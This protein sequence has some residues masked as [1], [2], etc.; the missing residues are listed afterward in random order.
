MGSGRFSADDWDVYATTS[1]YATKTVD[2]I[3]TARKLDDA[4]NPHGIKVRESHDSAD[5]PNSTAIIVALDVTGSMGM[6]LDTMAKEG[7][8]TLMAEIYD[9]K[10]VTDPHVMCMG[11]GDVEAGDKAPLQVTQFEADLRIAKQ[12]EKLYLERGGGGNSYESYA[13]AWYFAAKHTSIDCF[14]KRGKKG[15][16]FT[17]GDEKPT[18]Y[19]RREDIERVMGPSGLESDLLDIDSLLTMVSREWEVYHLIVEEGSYARGNHQVLEEWRK[20]LGQHAIPLSDHKKLAEVI[21][22]I[23]S[24]SAGMDAHTVV[25]SWD[26]ST[27]LVVSR[28]VSDIAVRTSSGG[29]INL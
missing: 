26:S 1:S 4:L 12:L 15:Y 11:I 18:P 2:A 29:V 19:L 22:S 13:L 7:L 23:L 10:P 28:A 6:L 25:R 17:L 27:S 21:V 9:R 8:P 16:L 20:V 5:N 3:Y 24:V 14:K